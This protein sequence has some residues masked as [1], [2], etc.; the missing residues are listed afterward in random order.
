MLPVTSPLHF[1]TYTAS[2]QVSVYVNS[3]QF[4]KFGV[5]TTVTV[6]DTV[7]WAVRLCYI[8]QIC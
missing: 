3:Q 6:K 8:I 2:S 4:Q 7:F 5:F 1:C